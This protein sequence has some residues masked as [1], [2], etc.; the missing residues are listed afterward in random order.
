VETTEEALARWEKQSRTQLGR[1]LAAVWDHAMARGAEK[2]RD[3]ERLGDEEALAR[4]IAAVDAEKS[5]WTRYDLG[6]QLTL[7]LHV[8]RDVDGAR[9]VARVDELVDAALGGTTGA[10]RVVK[11]SA[12]AVSET[13]AVLRRRSD[14]GSVYEQHGVQRWSTD[15]GLARE[16]RVLEA[17]RR[18][19]GP[20]VD[21]D[22]VDRCLAAETAGLS[23]DQAQ[24]ARQVLTSGHNVEVLVGPARHRQD[25]HHGRGRQ[26][27]AG[28][29][30]RGQGFGGGRDSGAHT[31]RSRRDRHRQH[32]QAAVRTSAPEPAAKGPG[33]VAGTLG[34]QGW[35]AGHPRRGRDGV[36]PG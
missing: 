8:D 30:R 26:G 12:P 15:D 11:L 27:V 20:S 9:L 14:N 1:S 31:G 6:G 24:A 18:A 29:R 17:A 5:T 28:R 13:P 10:G 25:P 3:V 35:F 22:L 4:A 21:G 19:A 7:T 23:P 16:L 32:R 34:H 36:T 2:Q 33:G